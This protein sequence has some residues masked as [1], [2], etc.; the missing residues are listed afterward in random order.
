M[1][2]PTLPAEFESSQ[3]IAVRSQPAFAAS[4]TVYV[5]AATAFDELWPSPSVAAISP[6]KSNVAGSPSGSSASRP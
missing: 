5:P 6:E 2:V 4:D 1:R 3:T